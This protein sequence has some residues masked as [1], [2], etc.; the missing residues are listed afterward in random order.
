MIS[1]VRWQYGQIATLAPAR[2]GTTRIVPLHRV[3]SVEGRKALPTIGDAITPCTRTAWVASSGRREIGRD[4]PGVRRAYRALFAPADERNGVLNQIV[5][6]VAEVLLPGGEGQ[7]DQR[8]VARRILDEHLRRSGAL[9]P[10]KSTKRSV[11][12]VSLR[13]DV[14]AMKREQAGT[15]PHAAGCVN[16]EPHVHPVEVGAKG[17]SRLPVLELSP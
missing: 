3:R 8:R 16:G 7:C 11:R 4:Q 1:T 15:G 14:P 2:I 6:A 13:L 12:P 17:Q 5:P 9:R 10:G